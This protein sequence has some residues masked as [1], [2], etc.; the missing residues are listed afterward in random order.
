VVEAERLIVVVV[1]VHCGAVVA[2]FK[3]NHY[4]V[5]N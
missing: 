1:V 3:Q 4:R 5:F 2:S